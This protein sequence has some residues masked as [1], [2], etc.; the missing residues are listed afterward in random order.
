MI[1]NSK[2]LDIILLLVRMILTNIP[3]YILNTSNGIPYKEERGQRESKHFLKNE[4]TRTAGFEPDT[5]NFGD[6]DATFTPRP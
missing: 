3:P 2:P 6:F 4:K 1:Q 5:Q